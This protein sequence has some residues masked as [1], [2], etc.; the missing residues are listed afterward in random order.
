[1]ANTLKIKQDKNGVQ[2]IEMSKTFAKRAMDTFS[3]EYAKLQEVKKDYPTLAIRVREIKKNPNQE[4]FHGLTYQYMED[5]IVLHET[6]EDVKSVLAEFSD[7]KMIS[8]CHDVDKRYPVIKKWFLN[9]YPEIAQFG[10]EPLY[11][12]TDE[13]QKA[14]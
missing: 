12:E 4:H 5:Y 8:R 14:G 3:E 7:L 6:D 11:E 9:R 13:I 10:I 1:M 2:Y